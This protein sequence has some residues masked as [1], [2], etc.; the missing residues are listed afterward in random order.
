MPAEAQRDALNFVIE[1]TFRDEAYALSPELLA[2]LT[3]DFFAG[4]GS[5]PTWPV[6]DNI[7]SMQASTLTQLMNSTTLRRVYDNEFM[8]PADQDALTLPELLDGITSEIWSELERS[9]V[10]HGDL[11]PSGASCSELERSGTIWSNLERSAVIWCDPERFAVL[12]N[13]LEGF[14]AIRSNLELPGKIRTVL[15]FLPCKQHH[16]SEPGKDDE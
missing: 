12:W 11:E 13:D 5:E 4:F 10:I 15:L 7:L 8:P 9:V 14:G 16:G 6:H 3:K 1:S 2:R